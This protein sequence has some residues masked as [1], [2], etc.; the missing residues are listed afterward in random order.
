MTMLTPLVELMRSHSP[1]C[2]LTG[3]GVSTDCGIPDYRDRQ[4]EWKR[5][6]PVSHQAFIS[7]NEVRQ[8]YWARAL[9][10][11]KALEEATPGSAHHALAALEQ[12]GWVNG[13][14]TQNVDRL[15][16]RAGSRN[17][18]DLHG[19][20]DEVL[21]MSCG[22]RQPRTDWH[23]RL[24][25]LNPGWSE[26]DVAIAPD[27]DADIEGDFSDFEVPACPVCQHGIIKPDVV[28]F[29]ANVPKARVE[30]AMTMLHQ[31]AGLLVAGS[32]LMVFSGFRFARE[33]HA[34]GLPIGCLNQGR[35]R[36][37]ELY[38]VNIDMGVGPGLEQLV[39]QL[40]VYPVNGRVI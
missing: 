21:C 30:Q 32:S 37:D 26:L 40:G 7:S 24:A 13:I 29:G 9:V 8:R 27:G 20:G 4:G 1:W 19:R 33:A 36:A 23:S 11:F 34:L 22:F 28:F 25:R 2:V 14:I 31:S 39:K 12:N 3:A 35:T 38:T 16:Q 18:I 10:G 17:V 6:Q 15:H 5:P